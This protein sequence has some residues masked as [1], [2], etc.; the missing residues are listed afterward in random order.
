MGLPHQHTVGLSMA[1]GRH[2]DAADVIALLQDVYADG[3]LTRGE[4]EELIAFDLSVAQSTRDWQ[5]FFA[6]A[7]SEHVTRNE[8]DSGRADDSASAW[9]IERLSRGPRPVTVAGF[10]AIRRAIEHSNDPVPR[11]AAFAIEQMR[12]AVI[13]GD[14]T[15]SAW[16]THLGRMIDAA[17]TALL[18][19]LLV[20]AGG[21][22]SRPVTRVEAEAMFNLHD[23][24]A[25]ANNHPSF[26]DLFFKAIAHHLLAA[27]ECAV[28]TRREMLA[29]DPRLVERA[30]MFRRNPVRLGEQATFTLPAGS[31]QG[32]KLSSDDLAWLAGQI[33]RD[34]RATLA[35]YALLR[36]FTG[37]AGSSFCGTLENAA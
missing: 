7:I 2:I 11:L 3:V 13:T 28:L 36:L 27:A 17:D 14:G 10:A 30:G 9:L 8:R 20:A 35:E 4:A 25:D 32:A 37:E 33:M 15:A 12:A 21:K 5:E 1:R 29:P 22:A 24:V 31:V 23:A 18:H 19:S 34:G 6:A 26:D 16:R